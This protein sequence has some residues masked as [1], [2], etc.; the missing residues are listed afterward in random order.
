D[1]RPVARLNDIES[2]ERRIADLLRGAAESVGGVR[3]VERDA[4]RVRNREARGR[5]GQ[6]SL[7]RELDHG[8]AG[9]RLRDAHRVDAVCSLRE[10][11]SAPEGSDCCAEHGEDRARATAET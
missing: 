3:K 7:Q 10:G 8:A 4:W 11:L 1:A 9:A 5:V 2:S 6:R